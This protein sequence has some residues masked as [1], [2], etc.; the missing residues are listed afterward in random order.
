MIAD[1]TW[2]FAWLDDDASRFVDYKQLLEETEGVSI[3]VTDILVDAG[4]QAVL[5]RR[6]VALPVRR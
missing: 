1:R 6:G 5:Q 3:K 2:H 4:L